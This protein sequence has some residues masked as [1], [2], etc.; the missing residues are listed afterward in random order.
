VAALITAMRIDI[1]SPKIE[2]RLSEKGNKR[3]CPPDRRMTDAP[4]LNS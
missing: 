4:G 3:I 1:P 2:T